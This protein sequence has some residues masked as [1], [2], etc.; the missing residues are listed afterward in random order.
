[1]SRDNT[2]LLDIAR[3]ARLIIEFSQGLDRPAFLA[4]VRTQSAILHQLMILGEAVKRL[5]P[6]F[7]ALHPQIPWVHAARMR[8]MLIHRYDQVNLN[9]VWDTATIDVP[10]LLALIE[11]LL[12]PDEP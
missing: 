3:A 12:P 9:I 8:D 11:P 4:D 10:E 2:Y 7:L 1:M 5:S 6:E